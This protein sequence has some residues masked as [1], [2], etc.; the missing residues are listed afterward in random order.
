L[1]ETLIL[2][3]RPMG[4][5]RRRQ[6]RPGAADRLLSHDDQRRQWAFTRVDADIEEMARTFMGAA[7]TLI[8]NPDLSATSPFR[9]RCPS[10]AVA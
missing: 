4:G 3:A 1:P 2:G 7:T 5:L 10:S 8:F 9:T 6:K